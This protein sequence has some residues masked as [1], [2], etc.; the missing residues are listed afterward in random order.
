MANGPSRPLQLL[1]RHAGAARRCQE[2]R[3]GGLDLVCRSAGRAVR[4]GNGRVPPEFDDD[5]GLPEGAEHL[6]ERAG[7]SRQSLLAVGGGRGLG[8]CPLVASNPGLP[9]VER[10]RARHAL[11]LIALC[12]LSE[13][14][15]SAAGVSVHTGAGRVRR[16]DRG[17]HRSHA[18]QPVGKV[19]RVLRHRAGF[20][21]RLLHVLQRVRLH[22]RR[23]AGLV[24]PSLPRAG[25]TRIG[26]V[27]PAD[28]VVDRQPG[29]EHS[30]VERAR[31]TARHRL[32]VSRRGRNPRA[33]VASDAEPCPAEPIGRRTRLR[34]TRA[35]VSEREREC[36][37]A[38]RDHP[39]AGFARNGCTLP[40]PATTRSASAGGG[41]PCARLLSA[42]D[43]RGIR[44]AFQSARYPR[45]PRL[46][47]H[48][49]VHRVLHCRLP[50]SCDRRLERAK[51]REDRAWRSKRRRAQV[52]ASR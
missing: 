41:R 29:A 21:L 52:S 28:R 3:R 13:H 7:T 38:S 19:R 24:L 40:V 2:H 35:P 22:R 11:C 26:R 16:S 46:Q 48:R 50:R 1:G 51:R 9:D 15:A 8:Q 27:R 20:R 18:A 39:G 5:F 36:D 12:V 45:H 43:R 37:C 42:R 23:A 34:R 44:R 25:P 49:R 6:F 17:R 14:G 33:E 10:S 4:I 31:Q 47:P 30:G 32:Q